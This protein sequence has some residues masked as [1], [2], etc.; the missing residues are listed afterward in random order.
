[1]DAY[2]SQPFSSRLQR[3]LKKPAKEGSEQT[4][5]SPMQGG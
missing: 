4:G 1:M 5:L 2:I 3:L